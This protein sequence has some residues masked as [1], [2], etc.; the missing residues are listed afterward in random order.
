MYWVKKNILEWTIHCDYY[1]AQ[2]SLL[3]VMMG[4]DQILDSVITIQLILVLYC[5]SYFCVWV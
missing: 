4:L 3:N 5:R 2:Y 1:N